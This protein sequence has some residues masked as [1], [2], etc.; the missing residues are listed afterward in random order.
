MYCIYN[1]CTVTIKVDQ[2]LLMELQYGVM[3]QKSCML[4]NICYSQI[5]LALIG[6]DELHD[7]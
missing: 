2:S 1:V 4:L 3:K 5:A 7:V 6:T